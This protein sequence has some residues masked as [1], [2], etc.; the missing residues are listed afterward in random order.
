M[1]KYL[2]I[3][4]TVLSSF[5]FSS[6]PVDKLGVEGPLTFNKT[7]FNL[8]FSDKPNES[9][10]I[11]E[12]LPTGEK[13]EN[14]NQMLTIHLFNT[15]I[16]LK[17]AVQQKVKELNKRKRTD[18]TCKYMIN[19]SP[20][21]KEFMIDFL[22]GESK[23]NE[24]TIAEFNIYRY[25]QI[26]INEKGKGVLVYAYSKRAYGDDIISFYK[27]LKTDRTALLNEM[28]SSKMPVVQII[29]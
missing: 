3:L 22:L 7:S 12:Y 27:N 14:F 29:K 4:I 5:I 18:L 25:K 10:Y 23:S 19:E 21:G 26:D 8:A 13:S 6:N 16:E 20:D 2:F 28:I 15:D 17:N 9:Y 1:K 11:Q 24:M